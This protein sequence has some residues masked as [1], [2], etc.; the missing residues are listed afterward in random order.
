MRE[1]YTRRLLCSSATCAIQPAPWV[2]PL[3][4]LPGE[5]TVANAPISVPPLARPLSLTGDW[6]FPTPPTGNIRA[7]WR[8]KY[9]VAEHARENRDIA[10]QTSFGIAPFTVSKRN[11]RKK[12]LSRKDL[13]FETVV[14]CYETV[15][16]SLS[17]ANEHITRCYC[18]QLTKHFIYLGYEKSKYTYVSLFLFLFVSTFVF[19]GTNKRIV[20]GPL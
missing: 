1:C 8:R 20:Y 3:W 11:S 13:L 12:M 7:I 17:C 19:N 14:K 15:I 16:V 10:L 5:F 4:Q 18:R 9:K 6:P 2:S